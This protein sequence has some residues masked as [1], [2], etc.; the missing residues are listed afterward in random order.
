PAPVRPAGAP[1]A[2]PSPARIGV[3]RLGVLF[4]CPSVGEAERAARRGRELADALGDTE[5]QV[6][7]LY[8][9]GVTTMLNGEFNDGLALAEQAVALAQKAGLATMVLRLTRGLAL[10]HVFAGRFELARREIDWVLGQ[11][12]G[13]AE[14]LSDMYVSARWMRDNVALL[15]D[16]LDAALAGALESRELALR[17]PNRTVAFGAASTIAQVRFLR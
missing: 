8:F 9:H 3:A 16:D 13:E 11:L 10:N 1:G 5:S 12:D 4:S 15:S 17:A 6:G 2:G 14:K 7:L